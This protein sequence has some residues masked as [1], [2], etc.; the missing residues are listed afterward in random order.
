M[1]DQLKKNYIEDLEDISC[2]YLVVGSGA[3]GS[4]ACSELIKKNKDVILVEEGSHYKIDHFKGSIADSFSKVWRNS[5]VTPILGNPSF[6]YG[7][8]MC[9]G[10]GTYINGGLIYRT[11][12]VVLQDWEQRLKSKIYSKENLKP[13]FE[14]I[15]KNLNVT[16][17]KNEIDKNKDSQILFDISKKNNIKCVNVRRAIK[18]CE[19]NN[20]CTTGCVSGAKQSTLQTYIYPAAEKGLRILTNTRAEKILLKNNKPFKLK[21]KK[22][23]KYFNIKFNNIILACGPIQTPLLIKKSFNNS[24]LKSRMYVHHNLRLNV[25]FNNPLN[26][27]IGTIFTRQIQ[28]YINDGVLFSASN[29]DKS[30]LFSGLN[31][32]NSNQYEFLKENINFLGTYLLQIKATNEVKIFN[33]NNI[34]ILHYN[35][36]ESDFIKIKKYLLLFSKMM[37]EVGAK[38]IYLP[39]SNNYETKNIDEVKRSLDLNK[40][41]N[42]DMV[43]VHGMS[44][45]RMSPNNTANGF[46]NIEGRSFEY[47]NLYCVDASILPTSTVESPQGSIMALSHSIIERN[48]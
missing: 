26:S 22:D 17:E 24:S 18:N 15:E 35:L 11:A 16:V 39:F 9:L 2:D 13:I 5:G 38:K 46:F 29:F 36:S 28:E 41:K 37:F 6:G 34:P 45:A 48:F 30:Y 31:N 8:G 33:F 43:S 19:R 3:G 32:L 20:K 44:S 25:I 14:K 23:Q 10:G 4:V 1:D 21:V 40:I 7:E 42:L 27:E 47:E 12:D